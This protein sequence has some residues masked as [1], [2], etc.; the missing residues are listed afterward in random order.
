MVE[1][2]GMNEEEFRAAWKRLPESDQRFINTLIVVTE[3]IADEKLRYHELPTR[4]ERRLRK[5][6]RDTL[7][8]IVVECLG[9]LL[10]SP[11]MERIKEAHRRRNG[12]LLSQPPRC[13]KPVRRSAKSRISRRSRQRS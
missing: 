3:T 8:S 4:L 7:F 1:R 2:R 6:D 12:Q 11:A 10:G 9:R 5:A 13:A